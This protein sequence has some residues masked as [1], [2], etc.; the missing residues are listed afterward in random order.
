MSSCSSLQ[1][2]YCG[3]Q[4][5]SRSI[6]SDE[7]PN[8]HRSYFCVRSD[9][10]GGGGGTQRGIGSHTPLSCMHFLLYGI[11]IHNLQLKNLT[12][13]KAALQSRGNPLGKSLCHPHDL[14]M[15]LYQCTHPHIQQ[16]QQPSLIFIIFHDML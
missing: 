9:D 7:I 6:Y 14:H 2:N 10:T 3:Q 15:A 12:Q 5:P 16:V 1:V 11:H 13:N 4:T 8:T